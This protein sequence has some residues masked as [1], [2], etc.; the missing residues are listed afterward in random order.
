[1]ATQKIGPTT[2]VLEEKDACGDG[3][4]FRP[5][6]SHTVVID[7]L[8]ALGCMEHRGACGSDR[9][10]GDGAGILTSIP[11]RLFESEGWHQMRNHAVGVVFLPPDHVEECRTLTEEAIKKAGMEVLGWRR[12]PID[13]KV[14]GELARETCPVIQQIFVKAPADMPV[15]E[16]EG[17]L[18]VAR[19][20]LFNNLCIMPDYN[21]FYIASLSTRTIV[22]KAMV[23]SHDLALF[24]P[25]LKNQLFEAKWAV[26][27]RRFSTN[28]LPRWRL[29]QPFGMLAHNGEINTLLGNRTWMK[30][31]E[32]ILNQPAWREKE[33]DRPPVLNPNGSDSENLDDALEML[34]RSGQTPE[35][36][37]M[38]LVPEAYASSKTCAENPDIRDFYEYYSAM[39]EP[40]DGPAF[41]V[42]SDGVT[43]G[44]A[45]DRNGLRPARFTRLADGSVLL[46]SETGVLDI[47]IEAVVEKGRLGPGERLC[48]EIENGKLWRDTELKAAVASKHPYGQWLEQERVI[49]KQLSFDHD[50]QMSAKE[51]ATVQAALGYGKEE[52]QNV[53]AFMA[54]SGAEPVFSMGD[55]TPLAVLSQQPR[56]LFDY[57]RQRFAQV[58]NPAIDPLREKLVMSLDV[59]L[60]KKANMLE[61]AHE[62]AR[63]LKLSTPILN[64]A[65]LRQILS[66]GEP[67]AAQIL[68]MI[69]EA[70]AGQLEYAVQRLCEQA[71]EAVNRG[72]TIIVLSDRGVSVEKVAIPA[73][74]AVGAVHQHLMQA[75]LRL[76]ASL[77]VETGQAWD[78]HQTACL[79]GFGAQAVCPYLAFET[80]RHLCIEKSNNE[81]SEQNGDS[82]A[83]DQDGTSAQKG[84]VVAS[85]VEVAL[86]K[87]QA[88]YAKSL[89]DGLLKVMSKMGIATISSYI[90]A[91]IFECI[92]LS[93]E[94]IERCFDGTPYRI[95]GL[96]IEDIETEYLRL[97]ARAFPEVEKLANWGR[98]THRFDGE[99]HGNNP[100]VVRALHAVLD[101][102][103]G[104][105]EQNKEELFETYSNLIRNRPPSALRDLL[106][107]APDRE[108]IALEEVEPATEIVKRFCT[109][110]MS[111]GS[112]S[113]EAHETLAI[114]MNRLGGKSNSGEGGEDPNRYYPMEDVSAEGTSPRFP[115]LS[116]LRNGDSAASAI[117]QV[118][119][120]RF[121]VT[122][123]YLI[124]SKQL[125]IKVSQGAKPGEGGQ[126]PGHKVSDYI[127]RLRRAKTGVP[128]ISPAPHHDIYS[129]EDLAQLI[130]DL[131]QVN[132]EAKVS[133]KLVA[134]I[135]IGTIAAGVAKANADV[136]QISGHDGGTGAA[137]LSSIKNA[138]A[139][140]E[141]GLAE[142]QKA[143][144]INHLRERVLLRVDGGFRT[145]WDVVIGALMGA[146]EYG[147]GSIALVAAGCIMARIC[148]TNNCPVG[149]TTQKEALRKRFHG[150]PESVIEFFL[151]VAEEVRHTL[152]KLGYR[153]LSEV[154][155]R[156]DLLKAKE[157]QTLPKSGA[158][159]VRCL[160]AEESTSA[161]RYELPKSV[162]T[163]GPCLDDKIIAEPEIAK[164]IETHGRAA[165]TFVIYNTDRTVGGRLSGYIAKKYGDYGFEGELDLTFLGSAGQSFGAFNH[166]K[167]RLTLFGEANDYV[168]KGMN[169]GSI[170][171]RPFSGAPY[172]AFEN[173]IIGNTC[174]YGATG[175]SFYAAGRAGERFAVR[176]SQARAVIEGAGAHCCEYMTGGRV[177]VLGPVGN[178]FGAGMTGGIAYVFDEDDS[179]KSRFNSDGDKRLQR[180]GPAGEHVVKEMLQEHFDATGSDLAGMILGAWAD[181]REKFWQ[182]VPPTES[183]IA[184][185]E[186][187]NLEDA[188]NAA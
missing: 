137:P 125:E 50:M 122:P 184:E 82:I 14:L 130:Y 35:A 7:A 162:H 148:H 106:D 123:E 96:K 1:M 127:A 120:A 105:T 159:D 121:G 104:K 180:L 11:W 38:Q 143:L 61:P 79:L 156:S 188:S 128:L 77:V 37:L 17:E 132:P 12:V 150:S 144:I 23:R 151:L 141:L 145:G 85:L 161:F 136:I 72:K 160:L 176:N 165:S 75:G 59:H 18:M 33:G 4:V 134:G 36:S 102:K 64:E 31:R 45:M 111:L 76:S 2:F 80:V 89:G 131:R 47:P 62:G 177:L 84:A 55:D 99:F 28:T 27:H 48:V 164:A 94:I 81:K 46:S 51:L 117:R 167:V 146:D 107:F 113:K 152:A 86:G 101:L 19:K 57:F 157:G 41:L 69:F 183:D 139:P 182:V 124:T 15:D 149:I 25:D 175:G 16:V 135:G 112:L 154:I 88:N 3:F 54:E 170:V 153:S 91:Q 60:G 22:Y 166:D 24:Y 168:G 114:A 115:G 93:S 42:Y 171:I 52:V 116:G 163:N 118:A 119:S 83:A 158:L 8:N 73:L 20:S 65:E 187:S 169:G 13:L 185:V 87:M 178:N 21:S 26:Y 39:Q 100:Q 40:W 92:G 66:C 126:L 98:M 68:P 133:V 147:F 173:T 181:Y 78:I 95:T 70:K 10:S 129:I 58:T 109:G 44:A 103:A 97:H 174:L 32:P 90:G 34:V 67:F 6:A 138:G 74:I 43:V 172:I 29:A 5:Q 179:F 186:C 142:T 140:W 63:M 9:K 155:G 53:I 110:G 56:V 30:A 49:L 108:P 71:V